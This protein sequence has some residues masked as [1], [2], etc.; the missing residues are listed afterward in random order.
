[1]QRAVRGR[2]NGPGQNRF[3]AVGEI[4]DYSDYKTGVSSRVKA[5]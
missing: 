2:G 5:G 4:C 3:H 1:M